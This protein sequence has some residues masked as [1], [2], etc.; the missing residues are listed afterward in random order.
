MTAK[1]LKDGIAFSY[2]A[3]AA[4][5]GRH[6]LK[7]RAPGTYVAYEARRR[8]QGQVA[9]FNF[10][11][12]KEMGLIPPEHPNVMTP[13]L[14]ATLVA[15]FGII[16]INEWDV[17]HGTKIPPESR[18]PNTYMATR[19]LQLQ[20]PN[21]QGLYSGDGRSIWNGIHRDPKG[22][23]WDISSC[24]TGATCLSPASAINKVFYKSG[25][26]TISY[27]CGY[28]ELSEGMIDV[29]FSEIFNRNQIRSERTLALIAFPGG[30]GVT[31]R[32]GLNLLR[33]SHFFN[34]LR[35][36]QRQRLANIVDLFIER[37]IHNRRWPAVPA[38]TSP[39]DHMLQQ[40]TKTFA[41]ITAEFESS[42]VFCWLDWDGDNI[43]ADGGV[44]DFGSVRQLGLC[45]HAYK[46]DDDG[47]W[48][49]N[50]LEQKAKAQH[51]VSSFAQ[52]AHYLKTGTK[53]PHRAF[54]RHKIHRYFNKVYR[55][56]GELQ[57]LLKVGFSAEQAA[58][59]RAQ[60]LPLVRAFAK[61]FYYFERRLRRS[62]FV[63]VPDGKTKHA[64]YAVRDLLCALP[65]QLLATGGDR[66]SAAAFL[67][68]LRT[69]YTPAAELKPKA[70]R[71]RRCR[72]FQEHYQVMVAVVA[73]ATDRP[74]AK[75]LGQLA[76]RAQV[77][78]KPNRITGDAICIVG[79]KLLKLR[80]KLAEDEF[81]AL[82]QH[83]IE[84]QV[85]NPD[86][87][88][89]VS[90]RDLPATVADHLKELNAI[91]AKFRHGL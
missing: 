19:Y 48:S 55:A 3:I 45:H 10:R 8:P 41:E 12:A 7:E 31:V 17:A 82:V 54:S 60:E 13:E 86:S 38:G 28:S 20:H 90:P 39:Y 64:I 23:H 2:K 74:V 40:V 66:L 59:L 51:I 24:G 1:K 35:Q 49:T 14:A 52:L 21:K 73:K 6:P 46:F 75:V 70:A 91:M 76:A 53:K 11:L 71:A 22:R 42:Y 69:E 79:E 30:F 4:I 67:E 32:A 65:G 89:F 80:K 25:D 29:L 61:D 15:T 72:S 37:E 63:K 84:S 87:E 58:L 77:I 47:K 57:L 26:K 44:I 36:K 5:D 62:G 78:N 18:L 50:L 85:T 43:L 68:L 9:F 16:I 27:G 83:F 56:H 33:P 34:H 81:Y 88:A